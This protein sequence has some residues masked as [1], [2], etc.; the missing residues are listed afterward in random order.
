MLLVTAL[1]LALDF[2]PWLTLLSWL[3]AAKDGVLVLLCVAAGQ[4]MLVALAG[5]AL[6]FVLRRREVPKT[7]ETIWDRFTL[8]ARKMMDGS[9]LYALEFNHE[10][11]GTEHI[12]LGLCDSDGVAFHALQRLKHNISAVRDAVRQKMVKGPEPA[13]DMTNASLP[14]TVEAKRVLEL[15]VEEART[16]EKNYVGSEHLVIGLL[17]ES[18][19]LAAKTLHEHGIEL[20]LLRQAIL[21][22]QLGR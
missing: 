3:A 11:I 17:R 10:Y 21:D 19:G 15:S 18:D 4:F 7:P 13:H 12:L 2:G 6:E 1:I 22:V 8:R 16:L 5:I 14:F 20:D 9:R